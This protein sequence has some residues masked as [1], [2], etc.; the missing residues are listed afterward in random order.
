MSVNIRVTDSTGAFA[1]RSL[2]YAVNNPVPPT[3]TKIIGM[4]AP[5]NQWNQRIAEVGPGI[6]AR[7]IFG[8][9][10]ST[11]TS[12]LT[13]INTAINDGMLPV[14]SYKVPNPVSAGTGTYNTWAQNAAAN[15]AALDTPIAVSI[16]HEPHNDMTPAQF[17]A[18]Q[19]Q[20]VPIFKRGKLRVGPLL[21]GWLLDNR[22]SDFNSYTSPT[23]FNTWDWFGI[24]T[25][26]TGT[27]DAP[28]PYK[29]ASR[30]PKLVS[31]LAS[32]GKSTMPIGVGEYNGY[33]YQ[34]IKDMGEALLSTPQVWFGCVW[35]DTLEVG[36]VLSGARLTAFRET[37]ADPRALD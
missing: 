21:N 18:M 30:M 28:G 3:G 8:D 36:V 33:S 35:N 4:N 6:K 13:L 16:W 5:Q 11:G 1:T 26:E 27:M 29:P 14:M 17:V 10:T 34:S 2:N 12:Q 9:L 32:K 15:L 37:L 7:R 24:D 22:L 20:L 19:E 31:Y 23:L 25:Y